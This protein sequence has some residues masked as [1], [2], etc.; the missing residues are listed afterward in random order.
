MSYQAMKRHGR[1]L[2]VYFYIVKATNLQKLHTILSNYMTFWKRKNFGDNEKI[3][4]CW[5]E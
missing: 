1:I 3:S 4:G 5:W 2:N